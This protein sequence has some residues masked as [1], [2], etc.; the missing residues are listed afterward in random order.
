M[1]LSSSPERD[2]NWCQLQFFFALRLPLVF[3]HL[4]IHSSPGPEPILTKANSQTSSWNSVSRP[5][6]TH[7]GPNADGW[8]LCPKSS[9]LV[10]AARG[11]ES[12]GPA[13]PL[14][15]AFPAHCIGPAQESGL[16]PLTPPRPRLPLLCYLAFNINSITGAVLN[17]SPWFHKDFLHATM[18]H[19]LCKALGRK[20]ECD[21]GF[22]QSSINKQL[23]YDILIER[24]MEN[25]MLILRRKCSLLRRVQENLQV[26]WIGYLKIVC[27]MNKAENAAGIRTAWEP[28]NSVTQSRVCESGLAGWLDSEPGAWEGHS[29]PFLSRCFLSL[30]AA[31]PAPPCIVWAEL[32]SLASP[33]SNSNDIPSLQLKPDFQKYPLDPTGWRKGNYFSTWV[34]WAEECP[35]NSYKIWKYKSFWDGSLRTCS[36][37]PD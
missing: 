25:G 15:L 20:C 8:V 5:R 19:I 18:C 13:T 1:H 10:C 33:L 6:P 9:S 30:T 14:G 27:Q 28:W 3:L 11:R 21:R 7:W 23:Q 12:L 2:W 24:K 31:Q 32:P 35:P 4:Q 17:S 29:W 36:W 34:L 16:P 26:T 37:K 22:P